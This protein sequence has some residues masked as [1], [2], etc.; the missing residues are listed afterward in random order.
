MHIFSSLSP[1]PFTYCLS[2][3]Q[4][5]LLNHVQDPQKLGNGSTPKWGIIVNPKLILHV[6]IHFLL[7]LTCL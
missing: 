2:I 5:L 6:F 1:V 7:C 4:F 3:W